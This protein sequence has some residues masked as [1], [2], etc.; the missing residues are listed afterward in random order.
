LPASTEAVEKTAHR[1]PIVKVLV[2]R[3]SSIGDIVLSSPVLRCLKQQRGAALHYLTKRSFAPILEANPHVDRVFAFEKD[4]DEHLAALR[5]ERYD[6]VVDL[7]QNLRSAR[8]K[9]ALGRPSRA[10]PKLNIEKWLLVNTG[11][12]LLPERH[13]VQRYMDAAAP[14]GVRYDGA[15]LDFFVP[16][17]QG[18]HDGAGAT[19]LPTRPFV[20]FVLGATHATKRLPEAKVVEICRQVPHPVLLLGGAAE[21]PLGE[22]VAAAAGSHVASACGQLSLFESASALGEA[23]VVLTHDTGLMHIAAALRRPIVSVWGS[24]VPKFGM[25]PFYP[26]GMDRNTS[27]QVSGLSCRPCSKIG[28]ARCPRGHFRCMAEM[29]VA[30]IVAALEAQMQA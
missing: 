23:A 27:V 6:F 18:I 25:F 16:P 21:R 26:T 9:W 4:V 10:F 15:G 8:V 19:L 2:L 1:S 12:D 30:A 24:T 22:Q 11:L 17:G 7:H 13:I 29:P 5:A 28:H 14:L 20:A 3:F